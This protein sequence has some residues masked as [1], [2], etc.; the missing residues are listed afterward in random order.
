MKYSLISVRKV[1]PNDRMIKHYWWT[2][3]VN[4]VVHAIWTTNYSR[5]RAEHKL[6]I[7]IEG[8]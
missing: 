4:S 7:Q 6:R 8:E 3:M 1:V 2:F 5:T